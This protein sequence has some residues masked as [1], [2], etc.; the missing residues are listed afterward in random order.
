MSDRRPAELDGD[1]EH[2]RATMPREALFEPLLFPEAEYRARVERAQRL[3]RGRRIGALLLADDRN[4]FYLGGFGGV[5]PAAGRTR[6]R[7]LIVPARGDPTWLVHES[8][9]VALGE[10]SW[11]P[12]VRTYAEIDRAPV[13]ALRRLLGALGGRTIG[14]ELGHEQRLAL[15][16]LDFERL[17]AEAD[18]LAFVDAS[19]LLWRLRSIKSAAELTRLRRAATMTGR[20][21]R[22][23]FG[24]VRTGMTEREVGA[25]FAS[26]LAAEGAQATWHDVLTGDYGRPN[27]LARTR[28]LAEGEM[29]WVDMGANYAGYWADFSRAGVVGGPTAAQE[30][31]QRRVVEATAAGVAAL[32]PGVALHEVAEHLDGVM[33]RLGL[34]LNRRPGRYGHGLGLAVT[35]PPHLAAFDDT[36]VEPGMVLTVEPG[37]WTEDGMYHCEESLIVREGGAE[38]LSDYP[39]ELASI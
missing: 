15:P 2:R 8:G 17:R 5:Q 30:R 35:E 9:A 33:A 7:F 12:E 1:G 13:E 37:M 21:Y 32:R 16:Y 36:I 39:R 29:V 38:L 24:R 11:V 14:A 31:M 23:A 20:A 3:M 18:R 27:G 6:P 25:V 28:R 10:M 26:A 19:D 22:R 4:T 34:E